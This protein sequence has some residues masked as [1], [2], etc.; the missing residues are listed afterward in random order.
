M[1]RVPGRHP[2]LFDQHQLFRDD[3]NL[4]IKGKDRRIAFM[5]HRRGFIYRLVDTDPLDLEAEKRTLEEA[6]EQQTR[7]MQ[8]QELELLTSIPG[9]GTKI[10]CLFLAEVGNV[11]R[12]SNASK[13]VAYSGLTPA[14]F[15]SGSSVNRRTRISRLGSSNLRHLL[16]MPSL[17]ATRYNPVLKSFFEPLTKI[18]PSC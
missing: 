8:L 16:Y 18:A 6:L 10:A 17:A 7:D 5:T 13:L 15:E 9:V 11:G 1:F 12:F 3:Q 4:F 2:H 14:L